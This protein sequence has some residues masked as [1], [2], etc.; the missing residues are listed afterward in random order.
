[1]LALE[2]L[3]DITQTII[4][5]INTIFEKLFASIDNNLYSVLDDVTFISSDI[6]HD[7]N[8]EK[9]FGTSTSNGILLIANSLL[10][11]LI[12][13]Y[14]I[15][16]LMAHFTYHKVENPFN[17]FIKIVCFRHLHEFFIFYNSTSIRFKF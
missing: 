11:G 10:L 3:T 17:F 6:L 4:D 14:A 9:I 15:R 5:T 12:L 16:F 7:R 2:N 13:Y 1:M 8:F